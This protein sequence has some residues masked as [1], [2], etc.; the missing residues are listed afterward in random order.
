[1]YKPSLFVN[2][3]DDNKQNNKA[4]SPSRNDLGFRKPK[5]IRRKMEKHDFIAWEN[6][7]EA[8]QTFKEE[9]VDALRRKR[10]MENVI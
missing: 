3:G 6:S 4:S 10:K 1:L 7:E 5:T 9:L 8:K 2:H